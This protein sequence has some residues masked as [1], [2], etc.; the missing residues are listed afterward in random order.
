MCVYVVFEDGGWLVGRMVRAGWGGWGPWDRRSMVTCTPADILP[1]YTPTPPPTHI[2]II[3]SAF[4]YLNDRTHLPRG[5]GGA[6]EKLHCSHSPEHP[7]SPL[8]TQHHAHIHIIDTRACVCAT[9]FICM[10]LFTSRSRRGSSPGSR[11]R[12]W[13]LK[14][15]SSI[16][17]SKLFT[18][19]P[20]GGV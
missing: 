4:Y 2:V 19:L 13:R 10:Y 17:S 18:C 1:T 12:K 20:C 3:P 16:T 9:L 14:R 6:A 8:P 15:S 5:P 7:P 11:P